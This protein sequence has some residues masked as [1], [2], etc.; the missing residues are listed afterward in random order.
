[1]EDDGFILQVCLRW[2]LLVMQFWFLLFCTS[3][4]QLADTS[5]WK[6]DSLNLALL[7][8]GMKLCLQSVLSKNQ[9]L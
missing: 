2:S 3:C 6:V 1:M 7:S 5:V 8:K 9:Q 4:F